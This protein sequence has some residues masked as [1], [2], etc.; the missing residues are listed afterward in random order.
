MREWKN[1]LLQTNKYKSILLFVFVTV[2]VKLKNFQYDKD[3][4]E[5][6]TIQLKIDKFQKYL[7][8]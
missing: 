1:F 2:K 4:L 5:L 3:G 8:C 7:L 6:E